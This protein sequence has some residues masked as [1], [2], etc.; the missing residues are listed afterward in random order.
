MNHVGDYDIVSFWE[1]M[2]ASCGKAS[3][4]AFSARLFYFL[5]TRETRHVI[6]IIVETSE[7]LENP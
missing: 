2:D 5:H 4:E 3:A 1:Q 7:M 6:S